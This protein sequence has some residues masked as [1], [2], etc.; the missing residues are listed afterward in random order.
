MIIHRLRYHGV[1]VEFTCMYYCRKLI[2]THIYIV[3]ALYFARASLDKQFK[4][5]ETK[6]SLENVK[7][8][9]VEIVFI[10]LELK[11]QMKAAVFK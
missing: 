3:P 4:L 8:N 11:G 9:E 5:T 6:F 10:N 2:K 1:F 7:Q